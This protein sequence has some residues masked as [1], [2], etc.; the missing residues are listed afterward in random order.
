MYYISEVIAQTIVE[1]I[2][3]EIKEHIN[4]M[5]G[6]GKIIASTDPVRIGMLHEGAAR[7][8]RDHLKELYIT[9]EM[10]STTTR[11]GINLPITVNGEIVGVVGITGEK[12]RV[13]GY[14]NIVRRMTEIMVEDSLLRDSRRYD[15]RV[16]YRFIEE[17]IAKSGAVYDRNLINR[18][19]QIGIDIERPR[20][21]LVIHFA[22][23]PLLSGTLEGQKRLE[24]MEASIRHYTE[25]EK[26]ILYL[27]EPPKQI[28]L[29]DAC[30]EE[31]MY[32]TAEQIMEL[33]RKKYGEEL[34]IGIDSAK[35]GSLHIG[36]ICEEA[37][38]AAENAWEKGKNIVFY[39]ELGIE[40]FLN[41][42]T[43]GSMQEY[44]YKLFPNTSQE[45]LDLLMQV[46]S[47]FFEKNG[48]ITKMAETLFMHKNTIQYKLKKLELLSGYDIRTPAGAGIYYMALSFYR[49]LYGGEMIL[50]SI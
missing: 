3:R 4:F 37:E 31:K 2:S 30:S 11:K 24:E 16:R 38:K 6:Q 36:R 29:I 40:L 41:E 12:E 49:R 9:S 39:H 22:A 35:H 14:G 34:L 46:V 32:K 1:E 23:Y 20:R 26:E 15:R 47:V 33:I 43:E 42:I 21:A 28:C 5:D 25:N 8:I 10:E 27:R 13:A 48:S 18:G 44:L 17:W 50:R 19:L 45:E 7:V